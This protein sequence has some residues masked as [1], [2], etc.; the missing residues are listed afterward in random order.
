MHE[1]ARYQTTVPQ[2]PSPPLS[3][4]KLLHLSKATLVVEGSDLA[5]PPEA[6]PSLSF[7]HVVRVLG[8]TSSGPV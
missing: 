5:C 6:Q 7:C 4:T 8:P 2:G 1:A 3:D